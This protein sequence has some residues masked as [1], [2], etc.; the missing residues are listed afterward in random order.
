MGVPVTQG[1]FGDTVPN[2]HRNPG[3]PSTLP[4]DPGAQATTLL[5]FAVQVVRWLHEFRERAF[6]DLD[7]DGRGEGNIEVL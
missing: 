2:C 6:A 4:L 7:E 5:F 3:W 1:S